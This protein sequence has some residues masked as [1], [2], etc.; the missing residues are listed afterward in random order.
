ML[1]F[2]PDATAE[3][4]MKLREKICVRLKSKIDAPD[5]QKI[6][7]PT[8]NADVASLQTETDL[9]WTKFHTWAIE[10]D[11]VE[12]FG[13]PVGVNT[14]DPTLVQN[15][16]SFMNHLEMQVYQSMSLES[17]CYHQAFIN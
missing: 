12:I 13:I 11:V 3:L 2:E 4:G 5:F 16:L 1:K 14:T 8:S 6:L 10:H 15:A 7:D 17:V 9:W